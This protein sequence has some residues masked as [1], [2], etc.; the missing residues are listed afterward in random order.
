MSL[1]TSTQHLTED[2]NSWHYP[3]K[4]L[5]IGL[6]VFIIFISIM[7]WMQSVQGEGRVVALSPQE[8]RQEL[9]TPLD[10]RIQKWFVVEGQKVKKGDQLVQIV[11]NDP[12]ILD[13]FAKERSSL[14]KKFEAI[15]LSR[16]V[17]ALNLNRQKALVAEGLASKRQYEL[18]RMELAKLESDEASALADISRMDVRLS[19]Q[20]QQ[21]VTAPTDGTVVRL[22]RTSSQGTEYLKAGDPLCVIVPDSSSAA[23]EMWI[24]GN[25]MPWV[26]QGQKVALQFEGWPSIFFSGVPT[27][28]VGTFFGEVHV[29]DALDDGQGNFRVIVTPSKDHPWPSTEHLK[30]GVRASSWVL[31]GDVPLIY[32]VWRRFNRFPPSNLPS[33]SPSPQKAKK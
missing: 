21:M 28:S 24:S 33:Y 14:E 31:L 1:P 25:D 5:H 23:V 18:A 2:K 3:I 9:T 16:K 30:Q 4:H 27:A 13:R 19:R 12:L 29:V 7:P 20:E 32:E 17:S 15:E 11:D 22:L 10:G 26:S 6:V 8:R